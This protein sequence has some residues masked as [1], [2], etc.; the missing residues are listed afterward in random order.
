MEQQQHPNPPTTWALAKDYRG[1]HYA[2][3]WACG[4]DTA[5]VLATV[6]N[7]GNLVVVA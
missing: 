3:T 7:F 6:D 1:E 4:Q 5:Q 2:G